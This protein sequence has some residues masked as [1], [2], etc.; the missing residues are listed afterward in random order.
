MPHTATHHIDCKRTFIVSVLVLLL[1]ATK[2]SGRILGRGRHA[3]CDSRLALAQL[4]LLPS[5]C[6]LNVV[7]ERKMATQQLLRP[8]SSSATS[9]AAHLIISKVIV[10]AHAES[11]RLR[12]NFCMEGRRCTHFV[13][14]LTRP[15]SFLDSRSWYGKANVLRRKTICQNGQA[16]TG[17]YLAHCILGKCESGVVPCKR[18]SNCCY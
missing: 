9:F 4:N 17:G 16:D 5:S 8:W 13:D 11:C 6:L 12:I 7:L 3:F 2:R 10:E 14:P 15:C 1:R 18:S